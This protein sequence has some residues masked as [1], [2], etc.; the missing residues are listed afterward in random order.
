MNE[1]L[2][3]TKVEKP[4]HSGA[5]VYLN[6]V[7]SD[8]VKIGFDI[9]DYARTRGAFDLAAG[10]LAYFCTIVYGCDK[11]V[12]R[13]AGVGDRWT[14][15]I[16]IEIP[17]SDPVRWE[18]CKDDIETMLEF[19][20]GDIWRL[21]FVE[22]RIPIFG[23]AFKKLRRSYRSKRSV[24][25]SAVSLFSGG[26]DSLTGVVD[27]LEENPKESLVLASTYDHHAEPA[28]ADQK[29]VIPSL[30]AA[31]PG[32]VIRFV[33]RAGLLAKGGDNNFRSR[34][35]TFLGNGVLAASFVGEGTRI[36]IPENGAIALNFPLSSARSGSLSTRTVHPHFIHLFNHVLRELGYSYRVE[37]PY[38]FMTKGEVLASCR[39]QSLLR[40]VYQQSVSCGK[41]KRRGN[42]HDTRARACGHCVPCIFRQAAVKQAGFDDEH[43]GCAVSVRSRWGKSDLLK[44]NGDLQTV[45]DFIQTDLDRDTIWQKLRSNGRLDRHKKADYV[46]LI[47]RLRAELSTWLKAIELI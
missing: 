16:A 5:G 26:L 22:Q 27:W 35:L 42:W 36:L 24:T 43:Y 45:I 25:G 34:S 29:R 19:L 3:T 17:V 14:R 12:K 33:S 44:P 13:D 1:I 39:N 20:T 41:R 32:R 9:E 30:H 2:V 18:T 31:Y 46:D 11:L 6:Q 7:G 4:F 40:S 23:S 38:Q 15:E 10:E 8:P 37:N 28:N 47:V 21:A